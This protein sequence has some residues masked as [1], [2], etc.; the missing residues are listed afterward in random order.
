MEVLG[1]IPVML[2]KLFLPRGGS[3]A[4]AIGFK[5]KESGVFYSKDL[6]DVM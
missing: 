4:A 3:P 1:L 2:I 6:P 5:S